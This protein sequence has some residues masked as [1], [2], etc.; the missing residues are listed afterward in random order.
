MTRFYTLKEKKPYP[1][2]AFLFIRNGKL[3][4][5]ERIK[6]QDLRNCFYYRLCFNSKKHTYFSEEDII[7]AHEMGQRVIDGWFYY[8]ST[9][10]ICSI[11]DVSPESEVSLDQSPDES[12]VIPSTC[13]SCRMP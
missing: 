2:K 12:A 1:G 3:Y 7:Q 10:N 4:F 5:G 11:P 6:H 9:E 13:T 8:P